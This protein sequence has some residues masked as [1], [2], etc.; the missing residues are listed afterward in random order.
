[1]TT[2]PRI[3]ALFAV[4]ASGVLSSQPSSA[5]DQSS[6]PVVVELF[7]SQ[8]CSSCPPADALLNELS[9]RPDVVALS[10][11]VSYWNYLGWVDPFAT[12]EAAVR[13][14]DY[15]RRFGLRHVY[16]PQMVINGTEH[17]SGTRRDDILTRIADGSHHL[18]IPVELSEA[19]NDQVVIRVGTAAKSKNALHDDDGARIWLLLLDRRQVTPIHNG[20]NRGQTLVNTHV[21]RKMV[22]VGSW[23]GDAVNVVVPRSGDNAVGDLCAALVQEMASG[24]ILGAAIEQSSND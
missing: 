22:P 24:R 23:Q 15:A 2:L 16:T 5:G 6:R 9:Q 13:Q 4:T 8:G 21:V 14:R 1:M 10:F 7:T 11:H 19:D 17:L 18:A 12:P 20:E 3:L